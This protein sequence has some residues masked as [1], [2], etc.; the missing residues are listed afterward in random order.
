MSR[1]H[2]CAVLSAN[3]YFEPLPVEEGRPVLYATGTRKDV[4]PSGLQTVFFCNGDV[5]QTATSRRVVYYHAE[6]DTTHVSEPDGTQLYHFPNG[7]VERHF[8]DG[9]KEIVFADGSLKVM[10][11]SGEV[12]EQVGAAG[13]LG[14]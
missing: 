14:V 5:K 13:P 9:L 7:Q 8:A 11:P 2:G 12:H 4:L 1:D 3:P 6:A 10:L